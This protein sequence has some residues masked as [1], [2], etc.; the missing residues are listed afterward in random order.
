[1]IGALL[2]TH[3]L[4]WV[5]AGEEQVPAWLAADVAREPARFAVSDVSPGARSRGPARH[6]GRRDLAVDVAVRW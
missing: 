2:D 1:M 5:L 3:S 6:G 4:L